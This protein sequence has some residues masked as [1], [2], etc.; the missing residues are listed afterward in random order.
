MSTT[1]IMA[2]YLMKVAATIQPPP[3]PLGAGSLVSSSNSSK[4]LRLR[5]MRLR[6]PKSLVGSVHYHLASRQVVDRDTLPAVALV[7][8]ASGAADRPRG[9]AYLAIAVLAAAVALLVGVFLAD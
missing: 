1:M 3:E 9:L 8:T 7:P 6:I 2:A 5:P 4:P